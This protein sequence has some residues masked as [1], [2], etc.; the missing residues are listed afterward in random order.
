MTSTKGVGVIVGVEVGTAIVGVAVGG[1]VGVSV[2]NNTVGTKIGDIKVVGV[3]V[4][5]SPTSSVGVVCTSTG[6]TT[7][8]VGVIDCEIP[9]AVAVGVPGVGVGVT[10]KV[11]VSGMGK[12]ERGS[13]PGGM[14]MTPGVPALGGVTTTMPWI[15]SGVGVNVGAATRVGGGVGVGRA[16]RSPAAQPRVASTNKD[17][18]I[19]GGDGSFGNVI[20]TRLGL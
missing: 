20:E 16:K 18:T 9:V 4:G 7:M 17:N 14:T 5:R 19:Q 1:A 13:T 8:T 3:G 12:T 15:K 6:T 10:V 2:A 11:G